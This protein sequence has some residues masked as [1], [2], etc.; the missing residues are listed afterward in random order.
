MLLMREDDARLIELA[1]I[2]RKAR[3]QAELEQKVRTQ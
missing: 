2:R 3:H 1:D